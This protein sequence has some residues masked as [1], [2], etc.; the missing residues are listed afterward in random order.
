MAHDRYDDL[1]ASACAC[2]CAQLRLR[3]LCA[4]TRTGTS[5]QLLELRSAE[6]A[7]SR[8][9]EHHLRLHRDLLGC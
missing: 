4:L 7:A 6:Q 8:A 9:R 1:A 3:R 5:P 2:C